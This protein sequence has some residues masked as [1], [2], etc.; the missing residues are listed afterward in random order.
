MV[1]YVYVN[2]QN[3]YVMAKAKL[4]LTSVK[5]VDHLFEDFKVSY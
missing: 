2:I 5:L 1:I 4:K 3:K